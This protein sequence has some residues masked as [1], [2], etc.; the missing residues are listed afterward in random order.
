MALNLFTDMTRLPGP[1]GDCQITHVLDQ[2]RT[3][4]GILLL[5]KRGRD[6]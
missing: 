1:F 6:M 4:F 3:L 2:S 5:S